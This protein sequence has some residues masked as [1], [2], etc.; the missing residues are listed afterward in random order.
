[1][2]MSS[3]SWLQP[4]ATQMDATH[5]SSGCGCPHLRASGASSIST[6]THGF[7]DWDQDM[8]CRRRPICAGWQVQQPIVGRLLVTRGALLN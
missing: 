6:H 3:C 4:L 5:Y 1:M 8:Y 7:C 2:V